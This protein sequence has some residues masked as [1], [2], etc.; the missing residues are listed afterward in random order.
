MNQISDA[1]PR[2]EKIKNFISEIIELTPE[3]GEYDYMDIKITK[4]EYRQIIQALESYITLEIKG[5]AE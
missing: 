1:S 2:H 4:S 3:C 5:N